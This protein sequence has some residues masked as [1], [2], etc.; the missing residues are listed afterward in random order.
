MSEAGKLPGIPAH[1]I[2]LVD[3][4]F[5]EGKTAEE[6]SNQLRVQ[7]TVIESFAPKKAKAKS[8]AKP[9]DKAVDEVDTE[10]TSEE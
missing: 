2:A 10:F 4:L 9:V 8:K 1:K 7:L 5:E 6:I 3:K